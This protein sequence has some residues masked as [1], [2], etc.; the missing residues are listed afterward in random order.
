MATTS[1]P[2]RPTNGLPVPFATL[3]GE[4]PQTVGSIFLLPNNGQGIAS[5]GIEHVRTLAT[6]LPCRPAQNPCAK[7]K[8]GLLDL[9]A[10]RAS[11]WQTS[12]TS[13]TLVPCGN[14]TAALLAV[15]GIRKRCSSPQLSVRISEANREAFVIGHIAR[16]P[17]G[18]R[19]VDQVWKVAP[20]DCVNLGITADGRPY[21]QCR[22]LND[23]VVVGGDGR[24]PPEQLR[25]KFTF[26]GHRGKL[27]ILTNSQ[28]GIYATTHNSSGLHGGMPMTGLITLAL[29][30][31]QVPWLA[32][33]R[34]MGHII[35]RQGANA[36]PNID[37]FRYYITFSMPPAHVVTRN[38]AA[39]GNRP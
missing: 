11:S 31:R 36:L 37:V 16:H 3:K 5:W 15:A 13:A 17:T 4:R 38:H 35:H 18:G 30:S 7:G 29:L 22:W 39:H 33:L 25:A 12:S 19:V 23:Y 26:G 14:L 32:P 10:Q 9:Q 1:F 2:V 27:I 28:P 8:V 6:L 24:I 20:P 34:R 21:A